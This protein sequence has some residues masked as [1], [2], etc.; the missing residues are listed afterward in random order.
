MEGRE[1]VGGRHLIDGLSSELLFDV[2]IT[3]LF[4]D[5]VAHDGSAGC[6]GGGRVEAE[7]GLGGMAAGVGGKGTASGVLEGLL[8]SFTE[9]FVIGKAMDGAVFGA[10]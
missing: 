8:E 7:D 4:L 9:L 6:W 2:C 3:F 5:G 1:F 10:K